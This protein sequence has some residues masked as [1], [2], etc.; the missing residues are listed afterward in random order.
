MKGIPLIVY[1]FCLFA[2]SCEVQDKITPVLEYDFE[3]DLETIIEK[4]GKLV[5]ETTQSTSFLAAA[6]AVSD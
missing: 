4:D 3:S 1:I 2:Y 6:Q 5:F